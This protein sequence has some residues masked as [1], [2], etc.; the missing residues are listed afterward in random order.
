MDRDPS[1]LKY[2]EAGNAFVVLWTIVTPADA[3]WKAGTGRVAITPKEP[4]WM[5]GYASRTRPSEGAV[6]DLWAKLEAI[7]AAVAR[8]IQAAGR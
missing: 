7:I 3:G 8:R 4:M 6:H 1:R 5:A 2:W